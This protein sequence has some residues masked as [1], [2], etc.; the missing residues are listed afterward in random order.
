MYSGF[1]HY[2]YGDHIDWED[3]HSFN[4]TKDM[5]K[6]K[7]V[8]A[9][10][11]IHDNFLEWVEEES[12]EPI[13]PFRFEQIF[14]APENVNNLWISEVALASASSVFIGDQLNIFISGGI[15]KEEGGEVRHYRNKEELTV[16]KE[17]S[18]QYE[19][20]FGFINETLKKKE[21]MKAI[22]LMVLESQT[23]QIVSCFYD[24]LSRSKATP[25]KTFVA[26]VSKERFL[27]FTNKM[28][29]E[30]KKLIKSEKTEQIVTKLM[31][32]MKSKLLTID[33]DKLTSKAYLV[34][35]RTRSLV[36]GV[37][38]EKVF[39]DLNEVHLLIS[40]GIWQ[41][42]TGQWPAMVEFITNF[43]KFTFAS[44][45]FWLRVDTLY[46]QQVDQQKRFYQERQKSLESKMTDDIL[47]FFRSLLEFMVD[48]R[49]GKRTFIDDFISDLEKI[50]LNEMLSKHLTYLVDTLSRQYLSCYTALHGKP[51]FNLLAEAAQEND[52]AKAIKKL[53]FADWPKDEIL[54]KGFD[55]F[56]EKLEQGILLVVSSSLGSCSR[57][58]I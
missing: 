50:D 30:L 52:V 13:E 49:E 7:L 32:S 8:E 39:E 37:D 42:Y 47:P 48:I 14:R 43:F 28:A 9:A 2:Y 58:M 24:K 27:K 20:A 12:K 36:L 4:I 51:D 21:E 16:L 35:L 10:L 44:E 41:T 11:K 53:V 46:H 23:E 6:E 26:N 22:V 56:V 54:P 19:D 40:K 29:Q 31:S 17:L 33:T 25:Y 18:K 34:F 1:S 15:I 55:D 57:H 5:D 38:V 45:K 3:L